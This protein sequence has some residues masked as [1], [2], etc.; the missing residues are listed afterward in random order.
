MDKLKDDFLAN[1]SHELQSPLHGIIGIADSLIDG[2]AG[3][4]SDKMHSNLSF[5]VL[6]GSRLSNLINDI[7]DFSKLK[8]HEIQLRV[9]SF[10][11]WENVEM[12]LR[13]SQPLIGNKSLKLKNLIS[14]QKLM[15]MADQDRVRIGW[16]NRDVLRTAGVSG[17]IEKDADEG[18]RDDSSRHGASSSEI[19][20]SSNEY[21]RRVR[22]PSVTI[23]QHFGHHSSECVQGKKGAG[24]GG[25]YLL[26]IGAA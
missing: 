26:G 25:V 5:I 15:V 1:T 17:G 12:A 9:Q 24:V 13:L 21:V 3:K 20:H 8:H 7:L 22:S 4:I 19:L 11:L 6:S 10:S 16:V 18:Y 14:N 2:S 23:A